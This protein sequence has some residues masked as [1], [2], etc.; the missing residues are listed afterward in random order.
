MPP[1]VDLS[2]L[3]GAS[4]GLPSKAL[5]EKRVLSHLAAPPRDLPLVLL[6]EATNAVLEPNLDFG[7]LKLS[8]A[9]ASKFDVWTPLEFAWS[10]AELAALSDVGCFVWFG[11]KSQK[12]FSSLGCLIPGVRQGQRWNPLGVGDQM[13]RFLFSSQR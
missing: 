6:V 10:P 4:D 1:D 11:E 13:H 2:T 8:K 3:H 9:D 5:F 7:T 12:R